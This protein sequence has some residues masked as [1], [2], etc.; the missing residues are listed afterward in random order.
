[1]TT[2]KPPVRKAQTGEPTTNTGHFGSAPKKAD[3][4]VSLAKPYVPGTVGGFAVTQYRQHSAGMEG[5]GYTAVL[6]KDGK[7]VAALSNDGNG[8]PDRFGGLPGAAVHPS[9]VEKEYEAVARSAMKPAAGDYFEA[10]Q[11][12]VLLNVIGDF[13]SHAKKH[14]VTYSQVAEASIDQLD[15]L[16]PEEQDVILH[17]EN[18]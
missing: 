17:P 6:T 16:T 3:G 13:A 1:M 10:G 11:F 15:W 12:T 2:S 14:R 4:D 5:G 8:G 9:D 7:P 18:H